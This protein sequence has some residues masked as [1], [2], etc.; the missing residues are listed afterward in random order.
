MK[1]VIEVLRGIDAVLNAILKWL[2][3]ACFAAL[4]LIV[5]ANVLLRIFPITSLHWTDEITELLF[6]TLVFYGA[7]AVWMSKGHFSVGDWLGKFAK[8]E[9]AKSAYRLLLEI[10]GLGF[11]LILFKYS[12]SLAL[13][14][15]EATAVFQIPKK[16]LYSCMPVSSLIMIAYSVAFIVRGAIGTASPKALKA[17]EGE[18]AGG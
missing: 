2:T 16:V 9:R 15:G 3:I 7:A 1:T 8:G 13:R 12:L 6:A 4:T 10:V 5:T 11:A 14:S 17:L 18:S